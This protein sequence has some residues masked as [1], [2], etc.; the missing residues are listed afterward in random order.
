MRA[1]GKARDQLNVCVVKIEFKIAVMGAA[2]TSTELTRVAGACF[3]ALYHVETYPRRIS[4]LKRSQPDFAKEKAKSSPILPVAER[5]LIK[6]REP[7]NIR[8]HATVVEEIFLSVI[9]AMIFSTAQRKVAPKTKVS[10]Y[11]ILKLPGE[12]KR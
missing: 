9:L 4:P 11:P 2:I 7:K 8:P 12:E 6:N 5:K 10:P 1:V 3:N